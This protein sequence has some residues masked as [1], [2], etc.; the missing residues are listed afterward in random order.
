MGVCAVPDGE[1]NV[2]IL[3]W[4]AGGTAV[5]ATMLLAACGT[6]GSGK[7]SVPPSSASQSAASSAAASAG[8]PPDVAT[9]ARQ[10][11]A[12]VAKATSVHFTA[13]G[14]Q[15][16]SS[17]AINLSLTRSNDMYGQIT[18]K[19]QPVVLLVT[20]GHSYIKVTTAILKAT[21]APSTACVLMC[22][23][24][25]KASA[26]QARSF[27]GQLGWSGIMGQSSSLP[28][29]HYV[30]AVTVNGQPAWE[31]SVRGKGTAY[32]AA[33]GPPYPLRLAFST[34]RVDFT[35]WNAVTIPPPPP[36]SKVIDLSQ[37]T[38]F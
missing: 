26:G 25:L 15:G 35:Q 28:R 11:N 9:L 38:H 37:L 4:R 20:R 36:A 18:Y 22:G 30:R 14:T 2:K 8:P 27:T 10:V 17:V 6:A 1:G 31:L 33:H 7:T 23:K 16:S 13:T 21:G 24:Y 3:R 32:V 34:G 12:A 29:L 19:N 5:V